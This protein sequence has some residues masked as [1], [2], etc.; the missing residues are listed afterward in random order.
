MSNEELLTAYLL[1]AEVKQETQEIAKILKDF[2][3]VK[4]AVIVFGEFDMLIRVEVTDMDQLKEVIYA[5]R[6]NLGVETTTL[7]AS[8]NL[9]K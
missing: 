8:E 3:S 2:S 4:D 1:I 6:K 9:I 5:L 7:V